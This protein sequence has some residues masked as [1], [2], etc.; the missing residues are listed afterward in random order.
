[1]NKPRI[2]LYVAVAILSLAILVTAA[3]FQDLTQGDFNNGIYSNTSYNGVGVILNGTNTTG[4]FISKVFDAGS[5]SV[6]WDNFSAVKNI[7]FVDY[8]FAVDSAGSIWG[9]INQSVS[10]SKITDDY[11]GADS[12]T[13][14][15]YLVN[16]RSG[17]LFILHVQ[18]LWKSDN[19][20]VSWTLVNGD[21]N[22]APDTNAGVAMAIDSNGYIYIIDS[23]E[24]VLKSTNSGATFI[25]INSTDFNGANSAVKAMTISSSD[26]IYA[27]DAQASVWKSTNSGVTWTQA[28]LDYNAAASNTGTA[29]MV[30]NSSGALFIINNQDLWQSIDSGVTWTSPTSDFNSAGDSNAGVYMTIDSNNYIYIADGSEDIYKS[31]NSGTSFTQAVANLNGASGGIFG[32]TSF[33][34][35][36]NITFQVRNCSSSNCA[37]GTFQTP[38]NFNNLNLTSRYFQYLASFSSPEAGITPKLNNATIGY[39]ILDNIPPT[40]SNY[41][42]FPSNNSAYVSAQSYSFF[43]SITDSSGIGKA[44]IE[45]QG[46]NYSTTNASSIYSFTRTNLAAGT[47]SY[48]W[49][50]NDTYNNVNNSGIRSYTISKANSSSGMQITG[51][52]PITYGTTSDFVGTETNLGDSDCVYSLDKTNQVYGAGNWTFNYSTSG[53]T[54]Y[55]SG[56]IIRNL[57]VNKA[58]NNLVLTSTSGWSYGYGNP[59][60]ISCSADSGT[61]N[62]Y[63]DNILLTNPTTSTFGAG[64]FNIKCNISAS[65]NYSNS[66][67]EQTLTISKIGGDVKLY[68][69]SQENNLTI[70]YPDKYNASA[71]TSYG[72]ILLYKDGVDIT[73]QNGLNVTPSANQA[74]YNL[75]AISSGDENHSATSITRWLNVTMDLIPPSLTIYSPQNGASYGSNI[76]IKLELSASD[77]NLGYCWYNLYKGT[78]LFRSNTTITNCQN[79]TFNASSDGSYTINLYANDSLGNTAYQSNSF[80]IAVGSPT[81]IL[82]SPVDSYSNSTSVTFRYTPT[83]NDLGSCELWGNFTGMFAL[84]Q[85]TPN[86]IS[87]AEN[88]FNLVLPEGS[89]VWNVRCNDSIGHLAFNGNKTFHIDTTNP[90]LTISQPSG[91]KTS[92]TGI[93]LEFSALDASP[94]SCKYNVYRGASAEIANTTISNCSS[95]TIAVTGDGDFVLNLYVNDSAGNL[96]YSSSSFSVSTSTTTT[97]PS[98]GGSGGGGGGGGGGSVIVSNKT[99]T[100]YGSKLEINPIKSIV[101]PGEEKSLQ[102]VVKN[103]G[104]TGVNKCKLVPS[105]GSEKWIESKD[106]K[107]IGVGEIVEFNFVM[108]V[109]AEDS[110][111]IEMSVVCLEGS[112]KVPLTIV[113][114]NPSL[115]V[116]ISK[117]DFGS[118]RLDISY[119]V[120]AGAAMTT[121]LVFKV[122]DSSQKEI[123]KKTEKIDITS[124][125]EQRNVLLDI[126]NAKTG[127]ELKILVLRVGEDKPLLEDS[128]L[129][130]PASITGYA[131]TVLSGTMP[132]VTTIV[133]SFLIISFFIVRRIIRLRRH[134]YHHWA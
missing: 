89:Y 51:T 17:S 43:A 48:R 75:T 10:W 91:A 131:S 46:A 108:D 125:T 126:S 65:Q 121:E 111:N 129:Y 47:Y 44:W 29:D 69:N 82:N 124:Q 14:T 62:I 134:Q 41:L 119:S 30:V 88:T 132:Y 9:S 73:A 61:P 6:R 96:N 97:P 23:S 42:D 99:T 24:D 103:K 33:R 19:L 128:I 95:T 79:T 118:N 66:S 114:M 50:A 4:I 57:T 104:T 58:T 101:Y 100:G 109:P 71:T 20:G 59:T 35:Y 74:V 116:E 93:P 55:T 37:D 27:V 22:G 15:V 67:T 70:E 21:I 45:W 81:I 60:T 28:V 12:N 85:T 26:V 130:N 2:I 39:T 7:T 102:V 87:G 117:I 107:N 53:C 83:D 77:K 68:L 13:G 5:A 106:I 54:N 34:K 98:T 63:K 1:M 64:T 92:R 72:T 122:L 25:K 112:A 56:S 90:S 18:D 3:N 80:S 84:N 16:N 8:L 115:N 105:T 127:G 31:T 120:G 49:W 123:S 113:K 110:G 78:S 40:F 32:L 76:S 11:N 36:T 86:P 52:T 94:I 133:I 38:S